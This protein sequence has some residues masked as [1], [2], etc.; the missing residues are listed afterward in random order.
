MLP[1]LVGQVFYSTLS[2]SNHQRAQLLHGNPKLPA[3]SQGYAGSKRGAGAMVWCP[4]D[5][6]KCENG[7]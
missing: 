2:S 7:S 6:G 3:H 5:N 4:R 1:R